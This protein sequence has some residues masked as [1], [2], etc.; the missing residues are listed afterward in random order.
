MKKK[1][2]ILMIVLMIMLVSQGLFPCIMF[3]AVQK[4]KTLVG[5]NEDWEN[6]N[7]KIWFEPP[8][9]GKFG[10]IYFGFDDMY[11]QGGMN[12]RGLVFDGFATSPFEVKNSRHKKKFKGALI[13]KVMEECTTVSEVLEVYSQYNL[14]GMVRYQLMF[15]DKTGDSVIIEGDAVHRKKKDFQVVTNF[16]LSQLKK[17]EDFPCKR[18][19]IALEI[20]KNND[21]SVGSFR[22]IL[23]ATHQEGQWGGTLYSNIYDIN[24]GL[25]YVY[26][27]HNFEN[28][29]V[30]NLAEELKKG[31]HV[32]DLPSLFPPTYVADNYMELYKHKNQPV[33]KPDPKLYDRYVGVYEVTPGYNIT[34]TKEGDRLFARGQ[35]P[36]KREIFP[37]SETKFFVKDE[38]AYI[39]FVKDS[40]GEVTGIILRING[41]EERKAKKI[42]N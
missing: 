5:N 19:K 7:T 25:I 20:L 36:K 42:K 40:A 41:V 29:V 1:I 6:P 38:I 30:I 32:I 24:R 14:E 12:D 34:V 15:V 3:K 37:A 39:T 10:R 16:Y 26:H 33:I 22:K 17:G 21:V 8:S 9:K 23:A 27:F 31:K 13:E 11:P 18:Y 4:G 28:V 35:S 2:I